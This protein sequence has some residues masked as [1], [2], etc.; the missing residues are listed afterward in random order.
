MS[1]ACE[2]HGKTLHFFDPKP[3]QTTTLSSYRSPR[4]FWEKPSCSRNT[5][6]QTSANWKT[7]QNHPKL[8]PNSTLNMPFLKVCRNISGICIPFRQLFFLF[9][10]LHRFGSLAADHLLWSCPCLADSSTVGHFQIKHIEAVICW[11]SREQDH[12][13]SLQEAQQVGFGLALD[14]GVS[15]TSRVYPYILKRSKFISAW[16][17]N[18]EPIAQMQAFQ[19]PHKIGASRS[20][21]TSSFW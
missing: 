19:H 6:L 2:L 12:K 7:V 10:A 9:D 17:F 14:W 18:C 3:I 21:S 5:W 15:W 20:S 11:C 8:I 1:A 13:R 16:I 4:V